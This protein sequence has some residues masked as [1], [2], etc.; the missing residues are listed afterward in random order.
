LSPLGRQRLRSMA[1]KVDRVLDA[2]QQR[3]KNFVE[4]KLP[5]P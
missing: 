2:P 5:T 4:G 3:L 1:L